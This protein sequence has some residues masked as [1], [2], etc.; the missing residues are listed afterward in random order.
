MSTDTAG[1]ASPVPVRSSLPNDA[2]VGL[3]RP[4][5]PNRGGGRWLRS[6][7]GIKEDILDWAPEER[8]RYSRLGAI[9]LNTGVLAGLSLLVALSG[10]VGGAWWA[11]L[12]VGVLWGYLI[13]TFDSWL[14]AST[15]GALTVS[16]AKLFVPRIAISVLLG[17]AIAEP[18]VLWVFSPSI[19]NEIAEHRKSEIEGYEGKLKSCNPVTGAAPSG[20]DCGGFRVNVKDSAQS[21]EAQFD[22]AVRLRDQAR[23]AIGELDRRQAELENLARD[24]CA[25]RAGTG[26]SGVP[27]VGGECRRNREKADQFRAD[28]QVDK[29]HADLVGLEKETVDLTGRLAQAR[30][31]GGQQIS[32]AI[33]DKVAGK[34]ADLT[35][36][37]I[38]DEIDALGRISADSPVVSI[39]GWVLRLLLIA[40]DCLP[41]LGKLMGGTTT[42]DILVSRQLETAKR[43]HDKNIALYERNDTVDLDILLQRAE[44]KLRAKSGDLD[45]DERLARARS[46]T[47]RA[48][49]IDQLAAELENSKDAFTPLRGPV[50]SA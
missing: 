45:Q 16:K 23:G 3:Y 32:Q 17:V 9:V 31:V 34:K 6:I 25:G 5:E 21:V 30:A 14:I 1:P 8:P 41:V 11:L 19:H 2:P 13:M 48:A 29:Q 44:K 33:A 22:A 42:Y 12:P 15:H 4:V 50:A 7:I 37:G 27:G 18:L 49:Q 35:D 24:E 26:L 28:N 46:R 20:S 10:V 43:L 47:D 39:A 36:R 40:V 38:L